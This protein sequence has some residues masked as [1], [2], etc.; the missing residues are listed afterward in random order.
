M[1]TH[2][3]TFRIGDGPPDDYE[4]IGGELYRL[5]THPTLRDRFHAWRIRRR[6]RSGRSFYDWYKGGA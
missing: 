6:V 2:Q 1:N 4:A 3:K 5:L